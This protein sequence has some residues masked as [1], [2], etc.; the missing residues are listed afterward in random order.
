MDELCTEINYGNN[1]KMLI[2][3]QYQVTDNMYHLMLYRVYLA[4]SGIRTH[5]VSGDRH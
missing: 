1:N 2:N 3:Q 4:M 5:N